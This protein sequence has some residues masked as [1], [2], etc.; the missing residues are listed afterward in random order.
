MP[1]VESFIQ[2]GGN[3]KFNEIWEYYLSPEE[4]QLHMNNMQLLSEA[5]KSFIIQKYH[6]MR[7][8]Q[9]RNL[10]ENKQDETSRSQDDINGKDLL[11]KK[12]EWLLY[13]VCLCYL[14]ASQEKKEQ[15]NNQYIKGKSVTVVVN[16]SYTYFFFIS[17]YLRINFFFANTKHQRAET[18]PKQLIIEHFPSWLFFFSLFLTHFLGVTFSV[19]EHDVDILFSSHQPTIVLTNHKNWSELSMQ[20]PMIDTLCLSEALKLIA[21][22]C[23]QKK[24]IKEYIVF[25]CEAND[26]KMIEALKKAEFVKKFLNQQELYSYDKY[27]YYMLNIFLNYTQILTKN[28]LL[29]SSAEN[30]FYFLSNEYML[31][32]LINPILSQQSKKNNAINPIKKRK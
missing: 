2:K 11:H 12:K 21:E 15:Q 7:W 29:C 18:R 26:T 1:Q 27:R 31:K 28:Y 3:Q 19:Q 20:G 23:R 32:E 14:T 16:E 30:W 22:W 4:K 9:Q 8:H 17:R 6:Q 5:R 13:M 10:S 25:K 24:Q